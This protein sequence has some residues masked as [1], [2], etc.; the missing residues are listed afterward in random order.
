MREQYVDRLGQITKRVL[1]NLEDAAEALKD[2]R[3]IVE[4]N[5]GV[6]T[7]EKVKIEGILVAGQKS[8]ARYHKMNHHSSFATTYVVHNDT[9]GRKT[10]ENFLK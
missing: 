6:I 8:M 3:S 5:K 9:I 4:R 2:D 1:Q 10:F 7:L